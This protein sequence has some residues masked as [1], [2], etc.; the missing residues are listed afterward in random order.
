M[1][2]IEKG[3]VLTLDDNQDYCVVEVVEL[4]G[5]RYLYLV[6]ED[7]SK[8]EVI[9]AEEKHDAEGVIVETLDDKAQMK[10]IVD[11]VIK[12]LSDN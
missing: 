11:I 8:S 12:R 3:E 1:E 5:K 6:N 7:E 9:I 4:D 2:L 10:R